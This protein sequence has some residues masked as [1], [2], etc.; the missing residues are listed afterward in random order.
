MTVDGSDG[1]ERFQ[2]NLNEY[3]KILPV[4][5]SRKL[6]IKRNHSFRVPSRTVATGNRPARRVANDG[7]SLNA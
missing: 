1:D 6:T 3:D 2:G 4:D 5:S 7:P